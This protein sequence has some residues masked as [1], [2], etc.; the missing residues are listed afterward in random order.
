MLFSEPVNRLAVS[1]RRER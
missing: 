1:S